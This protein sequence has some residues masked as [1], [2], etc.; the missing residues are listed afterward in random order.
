[1]NTFLYA[2]KT[3]GQRQAM[4]EFENTRLP[5]AV[6][7]LKNV[8]KVDSNSL[9]P[10]L[11]D[12]W[13]RRDIMYPPSQWSMAKITESIVSEVLESVSLERAQKHHNERLLISQEDE[14]AEAMRVL[15]GRAPLRAPIPAPPVAYIAREGRR[16]RTTILGRQ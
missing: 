16:D 11:R 3:P 2:F 1:M 10:I 8:L 5:Q 9:A 15:I 13:Y 12:M 4:E 6:L 14:N 7:Y